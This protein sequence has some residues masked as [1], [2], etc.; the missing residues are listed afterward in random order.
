MV[1]RPYWGPV[2][3]FLKSIS[4]VSEEKRDRGSKRKEKSSER[5]KMNYLKVW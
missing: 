4:G 1:Q 2:G 3:D 5:A